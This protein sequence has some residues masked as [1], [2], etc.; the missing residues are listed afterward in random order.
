MLGYGICP[1]ATLH[2]VARYANGRQVGKMV[3]R[4]EFFYEHNINLNA[5]RVAV[6]YHFKYGQYI[7]TYIG[8]GKTNISSSYTNVDATK[9]RDFLNKFSYS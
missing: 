7:R 6:F 5:L 1:L 3:E 2:D 8:F 9:K 4:N